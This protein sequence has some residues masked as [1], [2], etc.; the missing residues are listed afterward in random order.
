MRWHYVNIQV[1]IYFQ[2]VLVSPRKINLSITELMVNIAIYFN[3]IADCLIS[4]D[5]FCE[6]Q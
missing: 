6:I 3:H 4:E 2:W 5:Y 1:Q